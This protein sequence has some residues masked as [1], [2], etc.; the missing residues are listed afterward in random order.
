MLE[1]VAAKL[2]V[3]G[4]SMS[5]CL[6]G[7]GAWTVVTI[8]QSTDVPTPIVTAL[9]TLLSAVVLGIG[10]GMLN[11]GL[12]LHKSIDRNTDAVHQMR[13]QLRTLGIPCPEPN[14]PRKP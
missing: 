6:F 11:V 9:V 2:V 14:C 12:K 4:S 3:A 8:I 5:V 1:S 10:G 7:Y 13:N